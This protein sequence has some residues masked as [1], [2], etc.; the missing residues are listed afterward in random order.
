MHF[1]LVFEYTHIHVHYSMRVEM[2]TKGNIPNPFE[3]VSVRLH[4]T[5]TADACAWALVQNLI[6]LKFSEFLENPLHFFF[7]LLSVPLEEFPTSI[8]FVPASSSESGTSG[9][10]HA[11]SHVTSYFIPH[12]FL[13]P[14]SNP[15]QKQRI[16]N[17]QRLI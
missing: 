17:R 1:C 7:N 12:H 14:L 15:T 2:N 10:N 8:V 13:P 11:P 9:P 16:T 3:M 6:E 5:L 4:R